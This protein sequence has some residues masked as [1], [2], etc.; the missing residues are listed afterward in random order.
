MADGGGR[1]FQDSINI[2]TWRALAS[3]RGAE[4]ISSD[5]Y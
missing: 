5:A 3:T 1:F 2:Q 4:V